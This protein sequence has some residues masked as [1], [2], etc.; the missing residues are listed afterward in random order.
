MS[1]R[2]RLVAAIVALS[3]LGLGAF[4]VVVTTTYSRSQ[5]DSLD[6]QL[7]SSIGPILGRLSDAG[8]SD[9]NGGFP[10]G[11]TPPDAGRR[12]P[13]LQIPAGFVAELRSGDTVLTRIADEAATSTPAIDGLD[14]RSDRYFTTVGSASGSGD[15]RVVV[16]PLGGGENGVVL[17]VPLKDLNDSINRMIFLQ[18]A[19]AVALLVVLGLGSAL[20]VRRE[21][22]PLEEMASAAVAISGGELDRRV[23]PAEPRNEVGQLGFALNSMLDSIEAAFEQ[24][25]ATEAN[26]RR[27]LADASHELRTPLTSIQ[28]FAELGL[29]DTTDQ[30]DPELA[31]TRIQ[32]ESHRM[33]RLV[34]D[35]L[36]LARLDEHRPVQA[37]EVDLSVVVADAATDAHAVDAARPLS[38]DAPRQAVVVGDPD[39]IRQAVG[40]LVTNAL[41]HTP[42]GTAIHLS[43]AVEGDE[44]VVKVRDHGTGFPA[45]ALESVDTGADGGAT[46]S[47][48]FDRF[49]Q[50][51]LARTG[52]GSGLGLAIV[53]AVVAE[54]HGTATASNPPGGGAEVELRFPSAPIT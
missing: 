28:G 33:R 53:A 54:H 38:V 37:R 6:D 12:G 14:V 34:D 20:V 13:P 17:A 9:G 31:F 32:A 3:A 41:R 29:I 51:D 48:A 30:I 15:W 43:C 26:L 36:L 2:F 22:K 1:L 8:Q 16:S 35:L 45:E 19:G 5:R 25:D 46:R 7:E 10:T 49:W 27:F 4:G 23:T 50:A 39:L 47:K 42:A 40:N 18:T 11:N 24:R 44:V 52:E 21:L